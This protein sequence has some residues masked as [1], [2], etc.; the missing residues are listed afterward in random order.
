MVVAGTL[1]D[2]ARALDTEP[3]DLGVLISGASLTI[4]VAAP[5]LAAL[6]GQWDRRRLLT[7]C[8]LWYAVLHLLEALA[9]N[10]DVLLPL[11]LAS[12]LAPALFSPQ[13][14]ACVGWLAQPHQRGRAV[15]Y[16]FLGWSAASVLGMPLSAW[17]GN[18]FGWRAT[19]A[20]LSVLSLISAIW[21]S[22][23][24]P[25]GI[26]P[27]PLDLRAWT[28]LVRNPMLMLCVLCSALFSGG[29]FMLLAYFSPFFRDELGLG[30]AE[31]SLLFAWFGVLSFVGNA[32]AS[33]HIDR[34][35]AE[36]MLLMALAAIALSLLMWPLTR[37][38]GLLW[39]A[40]APWALAIFVANT[41]QQSRLVGFA[42][43]AASATVSFNAS[44]MY[45]G[46]AVGAAGGAWLL[47]TH[48]VDQMH[49]YALGAVLAA[50]ALSVAATALRHRHALRAP[51]PRAV[52][53]G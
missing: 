17:A 50:M 7:L 30:P 15:T 52:Q 3:S 27:P 33:R 9:P 14:A 12:M 2:M 47:A 37:V 53:G 8:M 44:A 34:L 40:V 4:C 18:H 23:A 5:L 48:H 22:R 29:Q 28:S 46:Q 45:G 36:R 49:W 10:L 26:R 13:A 6:V 39:V 51:E 20:A 43:G 21:L 1:R 24:M 42:P 32:V 16:V 25:S 41:A 38:P 11:R 35:G 31:L 19:F